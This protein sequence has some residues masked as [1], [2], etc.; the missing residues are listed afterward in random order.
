MKR[1]QNLMANLGHDH[2]I[3]EDK[4]HSLRRKIGYSF[5]TPTELQV[6]VGIFFHWFGV[7]ETWRGYAVGK[8]SGNAQ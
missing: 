5:L 7:L 6:H 8:H 4:N 3:V 2:K 1:P